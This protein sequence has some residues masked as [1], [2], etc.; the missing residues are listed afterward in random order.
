MYAF[1]SWAPDIRNSQVGRIIEKL[2]RPF[3]SIFDRL[4]LQFG[5]IDFTIVL[6]IVALNAIQR[7]LLMIA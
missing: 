6:A 7:L 5:G 3:L 2:S 4:P 1:M